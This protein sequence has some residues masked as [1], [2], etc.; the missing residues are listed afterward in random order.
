MI[1]YLILER[2]PEITFFEKDV[3]DIDVVS[4]AVIY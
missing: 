3:F 1:L 2:N 4:C